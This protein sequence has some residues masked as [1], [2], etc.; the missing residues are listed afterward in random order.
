[1]GVLHA[2]DS[3][4]ALNLVLSFLKQLAVRVPNRWEV[5]M[6]SETGR[7]DLNLTCITPCIVS[8]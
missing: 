5:P 1:M 6:R 4:F 3:T 8:F 2:S 7:I